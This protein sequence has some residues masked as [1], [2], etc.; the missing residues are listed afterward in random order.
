[1]AVSDAGW[2]GRGETVSP[3]V[4]WLEKAAEKRTG[5]RTDSMAPDHNGRLLYTRE[6]LLEWQS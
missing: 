4:D 1:M 5:T 6:G 3:A 2:V